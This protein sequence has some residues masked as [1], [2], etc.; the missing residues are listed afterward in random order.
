MVPLLLKVRV[1]P[2]RPRVPEPG[3][4]QQGADQPAGEFQVRKSRETEKKRKKKMS[5]PLI[6]SNFLDLDLNFAN[7][8]TLKRSFFSL[9]FFLVSRQLN[10]F[11]VDTF[12]SNSGKTIALLE[13]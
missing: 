6:T 7:N 13:L 2:G 9:F 11:V 4:G 3:A 12:A 1:W 5:A 8:Y 10:D